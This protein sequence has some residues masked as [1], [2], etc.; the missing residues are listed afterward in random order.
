MARLHRRS[1]VAVLGACLPL[2]VAWSCSIY[3]TSLL[4]PA[5]LVEAAVDAA[6]DADADSGCALA[7]WPG[8][9]ASDDGAGEGTLEVVDALKTIDFGIGTDAG[10]PPTFGFD[11][12]GV[13]TCPVPDFPGSCRV[14]GTAKTRCD[15]AGGRDNT[16]AV[17]LESFTRLSSAFSQKAI[18][19]SIRDGYYG[20]L[21]RI[22]GYNGAAND[23]RIEVAAFSSSG[24]EGVEEG[25]VPNPP[26]RDGT[27][28]WT[29]N[30]ASLVGR[31]GPPYVPV[32]VDTNAYVS[33]HRFV[34]TVDF[35]LSVG[36]V[37]GQGSVAVELKGSVVV[38]T[39]VP[40]GAGFR[41]EDG[42][43]TGR[44]PVSRL[45]TSLEVLA[46]PIDPTRFLCG[47]SPAY[48]AIKDLICSG[49]DIVSDV[50]Q[51]NTGAPCDSVSIAIAFSATPAILG[52][53]VDPPPAVKPC[54]PQ[55]TDD[56]PR[57]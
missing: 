24:N 17:L 14:L 46:D 28:R 12:D 2:A 57:P 26:K 38:G 22:R 21:V 53:I 39:L 32:S 52:K 44:W 40:D 19:E 4:E 48:S 18:N 20:L 16:V 36:T 8:R 3:N 9:P 33:N 23:P 7:R 5:P 29:I 15:F 13:C 1:S 54:G 45:L 56:C 50:K 10:I 49:Q 27:D 25:G 42:F 6:N 51:D 34:A 43:L 35:P 55:W 41:I 31:V 11:L 30:P 47:D 37:Q